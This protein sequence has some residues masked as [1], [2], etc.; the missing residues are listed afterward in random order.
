MAPPVRADESELLGELFRT[1]A[2]Q[3]SVYRRFVCALCGACAVCASCL[4]K[5]S[6]NDG[7]IDGAGWLAMLLASAA[8]YLGVRDAHEVRVLQVQMQKLFWA[9]RRTRDE[10]CAPEL[11]RRS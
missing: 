4:I 3:R 8:L 11:E 5:H 9:L 2:L 6:M 1:H 7:G 10:S